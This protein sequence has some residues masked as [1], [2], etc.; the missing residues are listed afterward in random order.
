M[1]HSKELW[2][3]VKSLFEMGYSL[4]DIVLDTGISKGS[5]SKR[6][7][8]DKWEKNKTKL[9]KDD[10]VDWEKENETKTKQKE[11][12]VSKLAEL[13]DFDIT[14]MSEKV[15]EETRLKTL[16]TSTSSLALIRTNQM[17]K[18]NKTYEKINRGD[19]VQDFMPRE[20]NSM[21][22][23]NCVESI[24]KASITLNVNP[25]FNPTTAIQ[26]NNNDKPIEDKKVTIIRRSD[27]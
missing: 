22:L 9:L 20:L 27:K 10:I 13:S 16:I 11:T 23:K 2:L 14:V 26:I 21:D 3:K 24:D 7:T 1:A 8:K 15:M 18:S 19:G 12:L 17:L 5:I 25:R 6:A 4:D